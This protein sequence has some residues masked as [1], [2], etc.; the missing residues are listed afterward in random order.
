MADYKI[1]TDS[2]NDFPKEYYEEH[3]IGL[4]HLACLLD[5]ETYGKDKELDINYFYECLRNGSMPTTS[6]VNPDQAKDYFESIIK[7]YSQ[8]L[9]LGFSGGLSGT[10]QSVKMA[11]D[12]IMEEHPEVKIIVIDTLCASL[13]EGLLVSKAVEL[14]D[15]GA[16]FK[17]TTEYIQEHMLNL[18]HVFTVDDLNHLYRGGR[19]SKASAVLGTMINIKPLLHVDNEGHL[20]NIGKV[21]GRKKSLLSL[22]DMMEERIGSYKD[23]YVENKEWVYISHSDCE[24]DAKFVAEEIKKRFGYDRFLINYIGPVIGS[25]TGAGTVAL[26]FWGDRR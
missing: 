22:V 11:A 16:S 24:E 26:F 6:Q 20:I 8:I 23:T 1:V 21:R 4:L 3:D 2:T 7:D 10:V 14:R 9:Y 12:E 17:E 5:G 18:C 25:H 15:S 13:G 19:V